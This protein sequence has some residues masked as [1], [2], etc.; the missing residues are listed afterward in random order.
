MQKSCDPSA[1]LE[2]PRSPCVDSVRLL[3]D[4]EPSN[5]MLRLS[6]LR[7]KGSVAAKAA[8]V[9]GQ[10]FSAPAK[11]NCVKSCEELAYEVS[12]SLP[13]YIRNYGL[14]SPLVRVHFE[15]MQIFVIL[16]PPAKQQVSHTVHLA[17][18]ATG[19][20]QPEPEFSSEASGN[21]RLCLQHC[22]APT[23]R[24]GLWTSVVLFVV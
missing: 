7:R 2:K 6:L 23:F 19:R 3:I 18:S 13:C 24:I 11:T 9:A 1:R 21:R 17:E 15:V 12:R 4:E 14:V 16:C 22:G 20:W 10:V 8:Y 5:E